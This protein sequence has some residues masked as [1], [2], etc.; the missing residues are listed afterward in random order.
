MIYH[1]IT[2]TMHPEKGAEQMAFVRDLAAR[3]DQKFPDAHVKLL[4]NI[5]LPNQVV[6]LDT[7]AS[8]AAWEAAGTALNQDETWLAISAEGQKNGL[9]APD[10][11]HSFYK[12]DS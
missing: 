2:W 5:A 11:A 8:L 12:V 1:L 9:I 10:Q 7:F 3:L 6:W 4:H